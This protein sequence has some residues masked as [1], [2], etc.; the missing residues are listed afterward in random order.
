MRKK[1]ERGPTR[2]QAAIWLAAFSA[3]PKD[4]ILD[5]AD[6]CD[7]AYG[8]AARQMHPDSGDFIELQRCM[9]I[10]TAAGGSR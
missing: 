3:I 8:K 7:Q 4:Y 10:L 1:Y 6:A 9:R 5:S 2:E